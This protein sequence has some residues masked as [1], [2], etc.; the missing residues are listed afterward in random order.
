MTTS[1]VVRTQ[2]KKAD[3]TLAC[4]QKFGQTKN[5]ALLQLIENAI[6]SPSFFK[7]YVHVVTPKIVGLNPLMVSV[8]V[9]TPPHKL[10]SLLNVIGWTIITLPREY[11]EQPGFIYANNDTQTRRIPTVEKRLP[12][13]HT[14]PVSLFTH[15]KADELQ[16][17][18]FVSLKDNALRS[19]IIIP[20]KVVSR[21]D[22]KN[23]TLELTRSFQSFPK[24]SIIQPEERERKKER[25]KEKEKE[26][27]RDTDGEFED[28][29]GDPK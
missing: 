11:C 8:I 20:E 14:P 23:S 22:T 10:I 7:L 25:E 28:P 16:C 17:P 6:S 24:S 9:G 3:E 5:I 1:S 12:T 18:Q 29:P 15:T 13:G 27:E 2:A 19:S 21:S 4:L 26:R